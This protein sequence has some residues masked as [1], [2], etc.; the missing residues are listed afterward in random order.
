[1][2]SV[3]KHKFVSAKTQSPDPTIV[4]K[5]EWNDEH[6]FAGG[7]TGQFL[8]YD[9]TLSDH[10][11]WAPLGLPFVDIT[12]F[13][14]TAVGDGVT[15][16]YATIQAALDA[17]TTGGTVYIPS[18]TF[19]VNNNLTVKWSGVTIVGNGVS[20]ILKAG[21][22]VNA[23]LGVVT[24]GRD[25]AINPAPVTNTHMADIALDGAGLCKALYIVS[26][27]VGMFERLQC[28]NP[29]QAGIVSMFQS[30]DVTIQHCEVYGATTFDEYGDGIYIQDC[31]RPH[32]LFNIVHDFTRIGI[33]FEGTGGSALITDYSSDVFAIGNTIYHAHDNTP[34]Q[35]NV[36]IWLEHT[37]NATIC[38][39]TIF[40]MVNSPAGGIYAMGI[41][42]NDG[43]NGGPHNHN[44]LVEGNTIKDAN[45]G[46]RISPFGLAEVPVRLANITVTHNT[47]MS[48]M[49]PYRYGI[50]V[51]S[52][53]TVSVTEN[54]F[55]TTLLPTGGYLIVVNADGTYLTHMYVHNNKKGN[56][57]YTGTTNSGDLLFYHPGLGMVDFVVTDLQDWSYICSTPPSVMKMR[58]SN[59]NF[60][61][62][63]AAPLCATLSLFVNNCRFV[64]TTGG[65]SNLIRAHGGAAYV[66][67]NCHSLLAS[68]DLGEDSASTQLT[69]F[70]GCLFST[71]ELKANGA[72]TLR[73]SACTV[74]TYPATGFLA[75]NSTTRLFEVILADITIRSGTDITPLQVGANQPDVLILSNIVRSAVITT[76]S[77]MTPVLGTRIVTV[78]LP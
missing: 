77:T 50:E 55:G 25:A 47:V 54:F 38:Y 66:F 49:V 35:A 69:T 27:T 59:I 3:L 75:G 73:M 16:N 45:V 37:I 56:V 32:I 10:V 63:S 61:G 7:T 8:Q 67:S 48:H 43:Q 53:S 71:C 68:C 65:L 19:L 42:V 9:S 60:D 11:K 20:S 26:C 57:T 17:L 72:L 1:M 39:N 24:I 2:P 51:A 44:V 5:N 33:C 13:P 78:S 36:G 23:V 29:K 12:Q 28:K 40:D 4:S 30:T 74:D 22:G 46:I 58:D 15:N 41:R 76:L 14:Y 62:T 64:S 34:P 52:G 31:A 21:T 6:L 70:T 18:G